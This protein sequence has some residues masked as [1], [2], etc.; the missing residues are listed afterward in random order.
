[1]GTKNSSHENDK[2]Y[3]ENDSN[4]DVNSYETKGETQI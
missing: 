4:N 2:K 3:S 1:M